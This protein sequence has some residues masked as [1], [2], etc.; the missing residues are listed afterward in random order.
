MY[1]FGIKLNLTLIT[2]LTIIEI[3][4]AAYL[5]EWRHVFWDA[6][7][8]KD[9]SQF[10]YLIS[11]FTVIALGLCVVD[12]YAGFTRN[13]LAIKWREILN[14]RFQNLKQKIKVENYNQRV[15][16]DCKEYPNLV[17][18]LIIGTIKAAVYVVVFSILLSIFFSYKYL[19][20]IAIYSILSTVLAKF[21]AK[22]LIQ[23][24]YD[25]QKVEATYRNFLH[26]PNFKECIFV[27]L[28]LAHK[29]K[30]LQ[31]FQTFY[32]QISVLIP[33]LI[34]APQY[35]TTALTLGALMQANSTMSTI[36]DNSSY[37]ITSFDSINKLISCRKRLK[38]CDII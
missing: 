7:S 10:L 21:I 12:A 26:V 24:N 2:I 32:M 18:T 13:I 1:K 19:I 4:G 22:P 28:G 25:H 27:M 11:L 14:S 20:I 9:V 33:L 16:E 34:I 30:R 37:G 31:Y 23:L 6:V 5:T 36:L 29:T 3:S 17:L 15:Q 8:L 38:E 35:F